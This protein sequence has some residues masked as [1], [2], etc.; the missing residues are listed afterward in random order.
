MAF[1]VDLQTEI[2][3]GFVD[4]QDPKMCAAKKNNNDPDCPS[5][6][7]AMNGECSEQ[8]TEAMKK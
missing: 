7:Q 2:G 6:F 8:S 1:R 3:T 4:I 5:F